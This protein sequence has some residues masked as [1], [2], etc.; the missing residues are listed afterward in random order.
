VRINLRFSA[1][2]GVLSWAAC[3]SPARNF[4]RSEANGG[5]SGLGN[6]AGAGTAGSAAVNGKGGA[7]SGGKAGQPNTD[8]GAAGDSSAGFA[9]DA[10]TAG[11]ING[12]SSGSSGAINGGSSGAINGGSGGKANNAGTGGTNSSGGSANNAGSS[13]GP[14]TDKCSPNPCQHGTCANVAGSFNCTCQGPWVSTLCDKAMFQPIGMLSGKTGSELNAVNADGTVVVGVAT[15][16]TR[17]AIQ[18]KATTGL[19]ALPTPAGS[20]SDALAV[21]ANG[22]IVAGTTTE[23]GGSV[24]SAS[25]WVGGASGSTFQGPVVGGFV[26]SARVEAL[27]SDGTIAAGTGEFVNEYPHAVRWA[28]AAPEPKRIETGHGEGYARGISGDGSIVVGYQ[29]EVNSAFKWTVGATN[30]SALP[31]LSPET[32]GAYGISTDGNVIVGSSNSLAVRW[33]GNAAPVSLGLPGT[34]FGVNKDG[35]VIVGAAGTAFVWTTANQVQLLSDLLLAQGAV[36]T[37]WTLS[38]ASAV[39]QDGKTIVGTGVHN[40]VTEGFIVRLR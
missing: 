21:S 30:A 16:A 31:E 24:S 18:W 8:D 12:G 10:N 20:T 35:S 11:A 22:L 7:G 34:A 9:G 36:L 1:I 27:S 29:Y 14:N 37:G 3:G 26:T 6:K 40:G 13:G 5:T 4:E 38:R 19:V 23:S 15:G 32:S 25:T 2:F 17:Q 28:P 39:S 33:V